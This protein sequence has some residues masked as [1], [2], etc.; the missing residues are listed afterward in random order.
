MICCLGEFE[1]NSFRENIYNFIIV[2]VMAWSPDKSGFLPAGRSSATSFHFAYARE[3]TASLNM[4]Q[5]AW[6]MKHGVF[7]ERNISNKITLTD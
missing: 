6:C 3:M 1:D 7:H 2:F 5:G 4:E